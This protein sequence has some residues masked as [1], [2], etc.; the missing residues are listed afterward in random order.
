MM[1]PARVIREKTSRLTHGR[2]ACAL[3][4]D[5]DLTPD[6]L[7][8][9][10]AFPADDEPS[11]S[12]FTFEDR[13]VRYECDQPDEPKWRLAFEIFLAKTFRA[14]DAEP[15][16]LSPAPPPPRKTGET[17]SRVGLRKLHLG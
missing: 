12:R 3:V 17:R 2:V 16:T 15:A 14:S 13:V 5:R 6:E 8:R 11:P 4:L 10:V 1:N 7:A 9:F